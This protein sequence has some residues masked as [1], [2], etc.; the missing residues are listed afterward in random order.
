MTFLKITN[1]CTHVLT[2]SRTRAPENRTSRTR[3]PTDRHDRR[4]IAPNRRTPDE[5]TPRGATPPTPESLTNR[6]TQDS[7]SSPTMCKTNNHRGRL[8]RCSSS[9]PNN[10]LQP[11]RHKTSRSINRRP[12]QR[13]PSE[14]NNRRGPNQ[15]LRIAQD[16]SA[17]LLRGILRPSASSVIVYTGGDEG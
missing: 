11:G 2:S 7:N 16:D 5:P 15:H 14:A 3:T 13:R 10:C 9:E 8:N 6:T 1:L 12:S 4:P 17:S